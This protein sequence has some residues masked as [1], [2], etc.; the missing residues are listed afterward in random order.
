M[1]HVRIA[2]EGPLRVLTLDRPKV[3]A[4][5]RALLEALASAFD[6]ASSDP[7]V[8]GVLLRAEGKAFSAGLDLMEMAGLS[9]EQL[10]EFLVAFDRSYQ[11]V[12]M[13]T[14]PVAVAIAGHAI[15][16]GLVIPLACDYVA[17]QEGQYK[18]GLTELAV[19][20]PFPR[21]AQEILRVA[22]GPRAW[23]HLVYGANVMSPAEAFA[24]GVGDSLVPDAEADARAWLDMV[25]S[26]PSTT[27]A[28]VKT[29]LRGESWERI[30]TLAANE[31]APT[32]RALRSPDVMAALMSAFAPK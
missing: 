29:Q 13:C 6:A 12:F 17:F 8:H 30:R 21:V 22:L 25:A 28:I 18:V 2:T 26:R 1:E 10:L 20:V 16:G 27:F 3:N 24:H 19:G 7:D 4:Q 9:D 11:R 15:A 23:R 14:K 5:N 32:A 31:R